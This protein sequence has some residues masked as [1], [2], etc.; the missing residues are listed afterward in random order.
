MDGVL[1]T[2]GRRAAVGCLAQ[3]ADEAR[4]LTVLLLGQDMLVA[5]LGASCPPPDLRA[6][7]ASICGAIERAAG[8]M[9]RLRG[10]TPATP[11]T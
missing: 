5:L 7:V 11:R 6:T 3:S 2:V 1:G 8:D 10:A 4:A 9:R